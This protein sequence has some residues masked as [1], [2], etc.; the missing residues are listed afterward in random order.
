MQRVIVKDDNCRACA[1]NY[2]LSLLNTLKEI[3]R[4][5]DVSTLPLRFDFELWV[6]IPPTDCR[7][8]LFHLVINGIPTFI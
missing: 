8:G 4:A 3:P 5:R 6:T 1:T 2:Y 7:L